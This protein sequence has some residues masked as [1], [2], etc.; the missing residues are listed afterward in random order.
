MPEVSHEHSERLHEHDLQ[1]Q[2]LDA[3]LNACVSRL[4][5]TLENVDGTVERLNN[6]IDVIRG[7]AENLVTDVA[8][9]KRN[10]KL[11]SRA[12]KGL[13]NHNKK[14]FLTDKKQ[15]WRFMSLV[16][17]SLVGTVGML[18]AYATE[19]QFFEWVAKMFK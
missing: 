2:L 10:S 3:K 8:L 19:N 17:L 12:I 4:D 5:T 9:L 1:I 16:Y 6:T 13:L 11:H 18:L 7:K 14:I 15:R